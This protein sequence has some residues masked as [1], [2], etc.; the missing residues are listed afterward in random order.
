MAL[1]REYDDEYCPIARSLEVIGERWTLL[2]LRDAFYG[3]TR[4]SDFRT[5]LGLPPAVLTERL[6]LLV[7]QGIMS[8]SLAASGRAEYALTKKGEDLW[9]IVWSLISW[10]NKY[11]MGDGVPR[12]FYHADCGGRLDDSRMCD[13][14]GQTPGPHDVETRKRRLTSRPQRDDRVSM[15]LSKSHRLLDPLPGVV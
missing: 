4:F 10:G 6:K 11:Y 5:H 1:P 13:R 8:T 12:R 3:V 9:P 15:L 14:C 2:I 7:E